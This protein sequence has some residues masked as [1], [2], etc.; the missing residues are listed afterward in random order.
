MIQ[1]TS[2]P[3]PALIAEVGRTCLCRRVQHA[4]RHVGR[5]FDDAFRPV[6]INNWQFTMLMTL[7]AQAS[8]TVNQI[9]ADLGMDRTTT[10]KNLRPL[11]RRGLIQIRVDDKDARVR[12]VSL[13]EAG[14]Q[15]LAE[16]LEN[17]RVVND[18]IAAALTPAQ[19]EALRTAL[20]VIARS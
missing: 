17:W 3:L 19:L 16:A 8:R 18:G 13:T 5:R 2:R 15:L 1:K 11:E 4:S 20:E 9:A 7:A 12:R 6:G 10:T 14:E